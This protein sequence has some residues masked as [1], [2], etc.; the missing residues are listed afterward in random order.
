VAANPGVCDIEEDPCGP[1]RAPS[2]SEG[3]PWPG[4]KRLCCN[5][6]ADARGSDWRMPDHSGSLDWPGLVQD[7]HYQGLPPWDSL[8]GRYHG[9][10]GEKCNYRAADYP[11]R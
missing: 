8:Q 7:L 6:L 11:L 9:P 1:I 10:K 3:L 2:V 4:S 5:P